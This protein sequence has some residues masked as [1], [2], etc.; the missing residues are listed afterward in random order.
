MKINYIYVVVLSQTI[1]FGFFVLGFGFSYFNWATKTLHKQ[2]KNEGK[3]VIENEDLFNSI[4]SGLI[5]LG[6][7]FGSV[8]I[9]PFTKYGRRLW[10]LV[11]CVL[12]TIAAA[13]TLV[14]NFYALFIGRLLLGAC[15]GGYVTVCPLFISEVSPPSISGS[16]GALNQLNAVSGVLTGYCMG[17]LI[18]L[19]ND[20]DALTSKMWRVVFGTPIIIT[21][22]QIILL[23]IVFRYDTPLFYKSKRSNKNYNIIMNKIYTDINYD[24][25]K[26]LG[27][28]C[29]I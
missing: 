10:L 4:V 18:P 2:Y 20:S 13:V 14:F 8:I 19:E 5:P 24:D 17:F 21:T 11:N 7:T 26:N 28:N 12:A 3:L 27:M 1:A 25:L 23:L 22:I 9:S 15:I 6:A 16:L 29:Q